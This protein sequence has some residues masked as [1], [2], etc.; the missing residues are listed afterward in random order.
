LRIEEDGLFAY[1][2]QNIF[3]IFMGVQS[4][5]SAIGCCAAATSEDMVYCPLWLADA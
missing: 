2:V 1:S 4:L 3:N 5:T